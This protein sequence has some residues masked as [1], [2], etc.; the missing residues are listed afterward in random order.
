MKKTI[1]R[2]WFFAALILIMGTT[3][4]CGQE[5]EDVSWLIDVLKLS[6]GSVVADIGAGDGSISLALAEH[7]GSEGRVYSTELGADSVEYLREVVDSA[8]VSNVT[9]LEGHPTRTN[10][11]EGCCNALFLRR[12]YHH[13]KDPA[14]MNES[15][16]QALKPGGR[17]AVIDFAPRGGESGDPEGRATGDHHG[18]TAETVAGELRQAGFTV[19]SSE[20]RSG[21]DVY[22]VVRKPDDS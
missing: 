5:K 12:V 6:E 2:T 13:F 20:Q 1:M 22:V 16:W 3:M 21:R 11:P 15:M 17:L 18:V 8:P 10:L 19:I 14:A 9:V 4:A 7:V